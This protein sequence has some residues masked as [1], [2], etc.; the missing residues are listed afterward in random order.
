MEKCD[1]TDCIDSEYPCSRDCYGWYVCWGCYESKEANRD[2]E[3][4]EK[5]VLGYK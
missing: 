5:C 2:R 1:C 3:Y 4:D